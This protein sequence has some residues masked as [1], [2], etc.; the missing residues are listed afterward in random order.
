VTGRLLK[1]LLV[2][3]IVL[4]V[5]WFASKT[6][7]ENVEVPVRLKGEAAR[8]PFYGAIRFSEVLGAEAAWERVFATPR[9]DAVIMLSAWNWNLSKTRRE[10]IEHWVEGGGRLI[11]DNT[12]IGGTAEFERWS[13][14]GE[15]KV[16]RTRKFVDPDGGEGETGESADNETGEPEG[17]EEILEA[18]APA[19]VAEEETSEAVE[20]EDYEPEEQPVADDDSFF[21]QFIP[22]ECTTLVEDITSRKLSVCDVTPMQSLTSSRRILWALR[23]G[24]KIHAVRTAVG[25][26]SVTVINAQPF[27]FRAF[28]AGDHPR[29]FATMT[30]LHRGDLVL[31]L[32]EEDH[33]NIV[34]LMWRFGAPAVLLML[35]CVVL[36]LWRSGPRF[37]PQV[38]GSS[39]A[40]RSLA[41]QIRGT[42]QFAL[43]FGGGKAL[44]AAAARAL[45]DAAIRK[46]PR[47]D[48]MSSEE[49]VTTLATASGISADD[50]GP[51]MNHIGVRS[52]H[53]LRQA[54]AVLE[55]AR[56]RLLTR[57]KH[58]N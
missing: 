7:F 28:L 13:G 9:N 29:L 22:K 2:L 49:R 58:G 5:A 52:T 36:A 38:A 23:D 41:E 46:F 18:G 30:Q 54:I 19:E 45:R 48:R 43:R 15:L 12:M 20:P 37:G 56:R 1:I 51:A 8:N 53:E 10:R 27:R 17:A 34:S 35:A 32:T 11:V 39:S 31:F 47:Y 42:G 6:E 21:G 3:G 24:E 50:L 4:A 25:S 16:K 57:A 26:G 40:R 33:A 55:S 14:I 44:H